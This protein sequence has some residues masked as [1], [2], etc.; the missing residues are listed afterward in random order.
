MQVTTS[1]TAISNGPLDP[2]AKPVRRDFYRNIVIRNNGALVSEPEWKQYAT[3]G[4]TRE[5]RKQLKDAG[6]QPVRIFDTDAYNA[7]REAYKDH[8][9]RD[10]KAAR[11]AIITEAFKEAGIEVHPRVSNSLRTLLPLFDDMPQ[12]KTVSVFK[13]VIKSVTNAV[14]LHPKQEQQDQTVVH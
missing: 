14:D 6:M 5:I 8:M 3:G 7:A 12:K 2:I 1:T 13:S 9:K 10:A 4:T 11:E